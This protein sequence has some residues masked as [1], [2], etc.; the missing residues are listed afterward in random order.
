MTSRGLVHPCFQ[1]VIYT[2][3]IKKPFFYRGRWL[4]LSD[5]GHYSARN[6]ANSACHTAKGFIHGKENDQ[7]PSFLQRNRDHVRSL[8]RPIFARDGNA[9]A[10]IGE[11]H[12]HG[13][14]DFR[15][16]VVPG[17][18]LS[19]TVPQR[20]TPRGSRMWQAISR[21]GPRANRSTG[22][23]RRDRP[24]RPASWSTRSR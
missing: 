1:G 21:E 24:I 9:V 16:G 2:G 19:V 13:F 12:V 11:V 8:F 3:G 15:Q 5:E 7:K 18:P 4:V 6:S 10:R 17:L 22:R 20:A 14:I 23:A